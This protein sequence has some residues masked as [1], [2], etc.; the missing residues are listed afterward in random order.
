MLTL[1][2]LDIR[3]KTT[4]M[5]QRN[6]LSA[7]NAKGINCVSLRSKVSASFA[8]GPGVAYILY[9]LSLSLVCFREFLLLHL[10]NIFKRGEH[11][12][13]ILFL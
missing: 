12:F 10:L 9:P 7:V 3:C 6:C 4:H 8:M 13:Y 5:S 2:V 1:M 11:R